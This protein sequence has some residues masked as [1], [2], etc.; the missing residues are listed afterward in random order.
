MMLV[1]LDAMVLPFQMAYGSEEA[2]TFEEVWLWLT[3]LFFA[4]DIVMNFNTAYTAGKKDSDY[5]PGRLVT[6]R[7]RIVRNYMRTWF[8]ID[9]ISTVPWGKLSSTITGG[10]GDSETGQ[11]GKLTKVVK[12][13]RFMRLMRMLRLAKLAAIWERIE[14]KCGSIALLQGVGLLR[15]L[16]VLVC[17]CH[18]NACIWWMI[19]QPTSLFTE[20]LDEATQQDWKEQP[21]WTTILRTYGA[22]RCSEQSQGTG[23][24]HCTVNGPLAEQ[25]TWLE[26][27]RDEGVHATYVFSFYWTLGVMRT[28]PAEITPVNFVERV[29]VMVFMFFAFSAFAICVAQ[30]TQT[31]FKF[32][33]RKRVFG[34]EMSQVRMHLRKLKVSDQ[35]QMKVKMFLRHLYDIRRLHSKER[36]MIQL[37][38]ESIQQELQGAQLN[39]HLDKLQPLKYVSTQALNDIASVSEVL[40]VA[41]GEMLCVK[42]ESATGCFVLIIGRLHVVKYAENMTATLTKGWKDTPGIRTSRKG[43]PLKPLE[44]VNEEV[45]GDPD[46]VSQNTV[47]AMLASS[48][49][50]IDSLS[51][52]TLITAN[53]NLMDQ[54]RQS[55]RISYSF[56]PPSLNSNV[57]GCESFN[58]RLS[59]RAFGGN[60]SSTTTR[61]MGTEKSTVTHKMTTGRVN[62]MAERQWQN[63]Q[64]DSSHTAAIVA[65]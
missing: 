63:D 48:V 58:H 17:I 1:L 28:M 34:D 50:R 44:V 21:H 53:P 47:L 36:Q 22:R 52:H 37:L 30:I 45:L 11:L 38:P 55:R 31:F 23:T 54:Q 65:S 4:S 60:K 42:G 7:S 64:D 16:F 12:F 20:I 5:E 8:P 19:G 51:F 43:I 41:P 46:W 29:Y 3:T 61:T 49:L 24:E 13:V 40:D 14:A 62:G 15:V 26:R 27:T 6:E 56:R 2:N 9:G 32:S 35:L 18:W 57:S 39:F 33:E 25:W 59:D 10:E